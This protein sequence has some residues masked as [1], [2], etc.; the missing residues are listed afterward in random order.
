[1]ARNKIAAYIQRRRL[2][3]TELTETIPDSGPAPDHDTLRREMSQAIQAA[4]D[5]LKPKYRRVL[6]LYYYR[7]LS[8][9]EIA[10]V[11]GVPA[12]RVSEWKDYG[13][14]VI[15]ER[16]GPTLEKFR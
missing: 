10:D 7:G 2:E 9:A 6:Y 3:T 13:H 12:R 14:K 16:F 5:Q 11:L 4:L 1:V 8:I 15:R